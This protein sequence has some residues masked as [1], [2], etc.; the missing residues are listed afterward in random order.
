M[1]TVPEAAVDEH[2]GPMVGQYGVG[3]SGKTFP[4][5]PITRSRGSQKRPE[6][7]FGGSPLGPHLAH[8]GARGG[9]GFR[10]VA[11]GAPPPS[12]PPSRRG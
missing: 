8:P 1:A 9:V 11:Q 5:R 6:G 10:G 12:S 2:D 3:T 4:I 7:F